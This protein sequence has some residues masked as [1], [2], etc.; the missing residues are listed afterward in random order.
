MQVTD[1]RLKKT[2]SDEEKVLAY[3]SITLDKSFVVNGIKV[4]RTKEGNL[5]V[6]YPQKLGQDGKYKDICY[7][8]SEE[9]REEIT[10]KVIA[11][12]ERL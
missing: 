3:G 1:V 7:A 6:G 8:L 10:M 2:G 5:F 11:Q 4:I 12:Y 9:M